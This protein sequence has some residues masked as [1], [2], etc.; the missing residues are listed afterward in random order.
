MRTY[1][2]YSWTFRH[3]FSREVEGRRE[4]LDHASLS[5]LVWANV[6]TVSRNGD[7]CGVACCVGSARLF[8][9]SRALTRGALLTSIILVIAPLEF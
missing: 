4:W 1:T 2:L 9:R 5:I 7:Q 6:S 8:C 3:L